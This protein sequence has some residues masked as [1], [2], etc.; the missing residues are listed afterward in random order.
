[1]EWYFNIKAIAIIEPIIGWF[2]VMQYSDKKQM[3]TENFVENTCLVR[4]SW[5]VEITYG[6]GAEFLGHQFKN[7]LIENEYV[8]HN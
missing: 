6:R 4:Y 7:I 1:M 5:P 8:I 2:E 3:T